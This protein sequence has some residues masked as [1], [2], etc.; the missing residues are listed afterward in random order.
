[1]KIP[2]PL[3]IV[4]T[5][6]LMSAVGIGLRLDAYGHVSALYVACALFFSTNL[7]I[8][9]WEICLYLRRDYVEKRLGYWQDWERETGRI[10]A[11]EYFTSPVPVSQLFSPTVWADVWA[12]YCIYDDSYADR[13]T[14]G[15]NVDVCNGYATLV[16]SLLLYAAL[17][18][19]FLPAM[20]T[21]LI[22]FALCWQWCYVTSVYIAS[23]F[24][25]KHH[26][27]ITRKELYIAILMPNAPWL[28]F[29]VLGLYIFLRMII[30]GSYQVMPF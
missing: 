19:E 11:I 6:A 7:L 13:R 9:Y 30:D 21:G 24:I 14:L 20:V 28:L 4:G 26:R 16:P 25:G 22:G 5:I 8:C 12:T 18:I 10:A 29:S 23:V 15:F 17:T 1:M 27:K 3:I 2:M